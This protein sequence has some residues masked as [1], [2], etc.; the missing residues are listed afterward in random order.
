MELV[1]GDNAVF[2]IAGHEGGRIL[3]RD[4]PGEVHHSMFHCSVRSS[5]A[6]WNCV[7]LPQRVFKWPTS[8]IHYFLLPLLAIA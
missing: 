3:W 7:R 6:L 4:F 1:V 2:G 5:T 8:I